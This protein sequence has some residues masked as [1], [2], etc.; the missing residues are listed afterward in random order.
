MRLAWLY[1]SALLAILAGPALAEQPDCNS[2]KWS[3]AREQ[4]AFAA[5]GLPTVASGSALPAPGQAA[6]LMLSKQDAVSFPVAPR[7]PKREAPRA[8]IFPLPPL[9]AAGTYQVTLSDEAWI[10]VEQGGKLLR[11]VGFTGSRTC[12]S[13]HKSVRFDLAPGPATLEISDAGV[14]SVK[15]DVLPKQ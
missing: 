1:G 11:Q 6:I 13:V 3:V 2:F 14:D 8:G 10:E 4:D 15:I 7:K 12:P 5:A 9:T